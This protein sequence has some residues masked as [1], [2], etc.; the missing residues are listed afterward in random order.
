MWVCG[1]S[2]FQKRR[3]SVQIRRGLQRFNSKAEKRWS[4]GVE[5]RDRHQ[6]TRGVP[7]VPVPTHGKKGSPAPARPVSGKLALKGESRLSTHNGRS[8]DTV[9]F[10]KA[11]IHQATCLPKAT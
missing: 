5:C 10:R 6:E 4:T 7:Q 9:A 11:V 8:I 1:Q 2:A 3:N